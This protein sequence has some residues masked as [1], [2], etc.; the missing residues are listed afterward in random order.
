[1]VSGMPQNIPAEINDSKKRMRAEF[2]PLSETRVIAADK[3]TAVMSN[4]KTHEA[5]TCWN[6][7]FQLV[8]LLSSICLEI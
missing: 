4:R 7:H 2:L 6:T 8:S 3:K 1:M 5:F